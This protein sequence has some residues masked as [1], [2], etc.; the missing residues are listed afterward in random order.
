MK[1]GLDVT[2]YKNL[3]W[4]VKERIHRAQYEALKAVNK[5]LIALYWDIGK[6]VVEKQEKHGWGKS[7]VENLAKD[8]QIEFPGVKGFSK[9]NIWRMRKFYIYYN[10]NHSSYCYNNPGYH[11]C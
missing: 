5:E 1:H 7:I 4:E 8:L 3:L 2:N 6:I 10:S 9:D 11:R